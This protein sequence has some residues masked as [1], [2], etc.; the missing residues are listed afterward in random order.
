MDSQCYLC[1]GDTDGVGGWGITA[2]DIVA[3]NSQGML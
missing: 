2:Y 3:C 1:L